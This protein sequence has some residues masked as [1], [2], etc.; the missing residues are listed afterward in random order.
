MLH[1]R[2]SRGN[3]KPD[4]RS[5]SEDE[6]PF[7]IGRD[8]ENKLRIDD[9]AVSRFHAVMFAEDGNYYVQDIDSTNGTLVNGKR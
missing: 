4:N 3:K 7:T 6:L 1:L 9:T 5:L 2:I 8:Q